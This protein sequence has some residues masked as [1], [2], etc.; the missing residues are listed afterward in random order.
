M[1]HCMQT[2]LSNS[3]L[4]SLGK[5]YKINLGTNVENEIKNYTFGTFTL[6]ISSTH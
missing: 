5:S 3:D 1:L 6:S 4:K 2:L